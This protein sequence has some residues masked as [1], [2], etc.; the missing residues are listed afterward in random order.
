MN[1]I[2][3]FYDFNGFRK[4]NQS[5]IYD[6]LIPLTF[7]NIKFEP[8]NYQC[9]YIVISKILVYYHQRW[10]N[11]IERSQNVIIIVISIKSLL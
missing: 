10:N 7:Y 5:S 6:I 4:L 9:Y 2:R 11:L 3:T 1:S 8:L